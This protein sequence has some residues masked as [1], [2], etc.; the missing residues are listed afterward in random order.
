MKKDSSISAIIWKDVGGDFTGATH[1]VYAG[2]DEYV[3][4]GHH[5]L[6]WN[7]ASL[8]TNSSSRSGRAPEIS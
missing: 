8:L 1:F 7:K 4:G 3:R 2:N 5:I 6:P